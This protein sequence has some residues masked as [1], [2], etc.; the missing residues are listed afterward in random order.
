[1]QYQFTETQKFDQWWLRL[2]LLVPMFIFLYGIYKQ[3]I[4]GDPWGSNPLSD[5]AL[6]AISILTFLFI[7]FFWFIKM[8]TK[9]DARGINLKFTPFKKKFY[10]WSEIDS[11]EVI[12]YGFVGGWGVRMGTKHGTVYNVKGNKGLKLILKN[13]KKLVIGTQREEEL[14]KAI[15]K[16]KVWKY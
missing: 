14:K 10:S 6:I 3:I 12:N 7:L 1:M 13:G 5:K 9:I 16:I 8:E 15:S 2:M 4:K 11:S